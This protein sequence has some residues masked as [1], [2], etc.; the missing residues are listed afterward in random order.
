[1]AAIA[2]I[3]IQQFI[4]FINQLLH[5][6]T[7]FENCYIFF[8]NTKTVLSISALFSF[9]AIFSGC[10]QKQTEN[11]IPEIPAETT[12][13]QEQTSVFEKGVNLLGRAE[14]VFHT[15]AHAKHLA[16]PM[17]FKPLPTQGL[18]RCRTAIVA[19]D[20]CKFYTWDAFN[21]VTDE[22]VTLNE[23]IESMGTPV[24][25]GK[26]IHL[27]SRRLKDAASDKKYAYGMFNFQDNWNWFYETEI[28]GE[29]GFIFGAD[30]YGIDDEWENNLISAELYLTDGKLKDFYPYM[31]YTPLNVNVESSL[32]ENKL[33]IQKYQPETVYLD[34]MLDAYS[35]LK[36]IKNLSYFITTDVAAHSQHLLFDRMLQYTEEHNFYPRLTKL[37][38]LFV[39]A[40]NSRSDVP[41]NIKQLAL[42]Y[43]EVPKI[44][45][46]TAPVLHY[47]GY[48]FEYAERT[49][50]EEKQILANHSE[51]AC[52]D[53]KKIM[54]ATSLDSESIFGE[55]EDFSQYK[56]RGHYTKNGILKAYFRAQMWY[57][58]LNF[59]F[60]AA[61]ENE[62]LR[63]N[64]TNSE[65]VA[66]FL[67]DV[68]QKNE[69]LY[70][71]WNELFMPV[72]A[73]IG[74]SDDLSFNDILPL[75]KSQN[76]S[77]F[78]QWAAKPENLTEFISLCR[79]KLRPPAIS[80]QSVFKQYSEPNSETG[81]PETPMGW[82]LFG[83]RFTYDSY[84]HSQVSVP[85]LTNRD[86][87]R[88][89][90]VMKVFG[91]RSADA[92]LQLSDYQK[93]E[94]L[95]QRLDGLEKDFAS[96]DDSFW[97]KS[98]YSQVLNQIKA[99]ATFEQGAGFYFTESP[100][101][102]IKSQLTAHAAWA[103]LRHDTI[104]YVKQVFAERA[105]DGDF[106]PTFRTKPLP[107]PVHYIEPNIPFWNA[108][109][110]SIE[111]LY[112]I[113]QK[114]NLLNEK[115]EWA[116]TRLRDDYLKIIE[117]CKKEAANKPVSED[118]NNWIPT[119][120]SSLEA[121]V[122]VYVP[123]GGYIMNNDELKMACIADV[124]TNGDRGV[125]LEVGTGAPYTLYVPLNDLQG[126]K[127]IAVG[128]CFSYY[129]FE[130]PA[131]NRLTDEDWKEKVYN[132]PDSLDEYMPFWEKECVLPIYYGEF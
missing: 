111:K 73:L 43:F 60:A 40:V 61:N 85:R 9:F 97:N 56:P 1:M 109:L 45:F 34:D 57:G 48:E 46:E 41:E 20:V 86:M 82:K 83:Q 93:T 126:G 107:K 24:P 17:E 124:F 53:Y 131:G 79:N 105:G 15:D 100:A 36:G 77:D 112:D 32:R 108:S 23:N 55:K 80:A 7:T 33:A 130:Q 95:K 76:V 92:L 110:A 103:E 117:I 42:M 13:P 19:S 16:D 26:I 90:D 44:I 89:L 128:Y 47:D 5:N 70:K 27:F 127:R 63:D 81:I 11:P 72:T 30:L 58:H 51:K 31:G 87:V 64:L 62:K 78:S 129:E 119:F 88:G 132:E 2:E 50:E 114:F 125:C 66:L 68:V 121:V 99:L 84:I 75:W 8:M 102:N 65:L 67:T 116:L 104:L 3:F 54:Q 6:D 122:K 120:I 39:Q 22:T 35:Q 74:E 18:S 4:F 71:N 38:D 94:G 69:E 37:T 28:D 52:D 59:L 115:S 96:A 10:K 25:F 21:F 12:A 49:P 91:S 118:E 123:D 14:G 98:Y 101:W 29:P 106:E 113:Y